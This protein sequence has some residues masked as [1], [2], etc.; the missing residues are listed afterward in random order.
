[1]RKEKIIDVRHNPNNEYY[2]VDDLKYLLSFNA[3]YTIEDEEEF[4][5]ESSMSWSPDNLMLCY[6]KYNEEVTGSIVKVISA[7]EITN[8]KEKSTICGSD[9]R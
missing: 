9:K 5:V 7:E 8:L 4:M 1:M 3:D 2:T 6:I